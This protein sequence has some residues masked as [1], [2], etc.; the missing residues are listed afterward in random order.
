MGYAELSALWTREQ[1]EF[2]ERAFTRAKAEIE[3]D[4]AAGRIR[5]TIA[6][7]DALI[8][9][10][11]NPGA[12]GGLWEED[13]EDE[14]ARLFPPPSELAGELVGYQQGCTIIRQRIHECLRSRPR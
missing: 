9:D 7:Y 6:S 5:E 4:I 14:G 3:N 10:V 13:I 1:K 2:A 8:H 11:E 12:Y